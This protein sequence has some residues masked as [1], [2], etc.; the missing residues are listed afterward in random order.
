MQFNDAAF[1]IN[2]TSCAVFNRLGHIVHV[3]IIAEHFA[4][5]MVFYG[6]GR[7][8]KADICCVGQGFSDF[9]GGSDFDF[10]CFF[11]HFFG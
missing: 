11:I 3:N 2:G 4:G 10:S 8:R 1:V 5:V 7:S 9:S 6:N